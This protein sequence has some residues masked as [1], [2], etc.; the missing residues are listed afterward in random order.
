MMRA[1]VLGRL[2]RSVQPARGLSQSAILAAALVFKMPAMSPTMTEGGIVE[3]KVKAGDEFAAGDVLLEVETDKATIDVEAAD[4]GVMWEIIAQNGA[5]GVPVGDAIAYLAEPGDDLST[6]QKPSLEESTEP[7]KEEHEEPKKEEPKKEEP[8]KEEPKKASSTE[9][10]SKKGAFGPAN[11]AQKFFPSVELLL[12]RNGISSDD[13]IAKIP[14]SGPKGRLLKGDVLAYLGE[15]ELSAVS[16]IADYIKSKEHLDLSNIVL[17]KKK[18]EES[19]EKKQD[20]A[21]PKPSNIFTVSF[22]ADLGEDVS[23]EKFKYAFEKSV[24]SAVR[25]TYA[26]RYPHYAA[27]P[28]ASS[29]STDSI[30]DDLL[31]PPVTQ[32]RFEVYDITYSFGDKKRVVDAGFDAILGFASAPTPVASAPARVGVE[33]KIKTN[34]K[35]ADAKD[36]VES[37]EDSL[38]AQIPA[39]LLTISN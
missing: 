16:K 20:V 30:F 31:A 9:A 29:G 26:A 34:S 13:A 1:S 2:A 8:K 10:S 25:I 24:A 3:W 12:H 7:K 15:I 18:P 21:P 27:S 14:A 36:F 38:L 23:K 32:S 22:T 35:V 4:D 17:A 5:S 28:S 6:L 11:P 37:F 39:N 19:V 33:F